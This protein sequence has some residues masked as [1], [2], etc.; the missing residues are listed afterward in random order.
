MNKTIHQ[1]RNIKRIREMLGVKQETLAWE[2]GEEWTQKRISQ[3]EQKETIDRQ[4]L[5]QVAAVLK[6]PAEAIRN[7]DEEQMI[8]VISNTATFENCEQPAFFNHYPTFNPIDK[9]IEAFEEI[10][11]LNAEVSRVK[12]EQ[13]ALLKEMLGK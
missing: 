9:L 3:L 4:I 8:S 7:F 6:L 1:G 10:K 13:I 11:R 12:D 5:E 2:L